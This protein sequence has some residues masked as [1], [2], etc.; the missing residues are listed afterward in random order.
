MMMHFSSYGF[1][2]QTYYPMYPHDI[3]KFV[4]VVPN[5]QVKTS[6]SVKTILGS[7]LICV[8][9][10]GILLCTLLRLA[11]NKMH[12][13]SANTNENVYVFFNTFGLSF[14]TTANNSTRTWSQ[15][16]LAITIS[17]FGL[18]SGIFCGGLLFQ[19]MTLYKSMP[20][21]NCLDDIAKFTNIDIYMPY[22]IPIA[23]LPNVSL[24]VF[25]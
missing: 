12:R 8:W 24:W 25:I 9:S 15:K 2:S 19:Q 11:L 13:N 18:L 22:H 20:A 7:P 4:L 10:I 3:T 21:I 6:N 5:I 1:N 23:S 16:C 14:G 17:I